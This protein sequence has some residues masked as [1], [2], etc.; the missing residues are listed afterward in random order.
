MWVTSPAILIVA[1]SCMLGMA[2]MCVFRV[3]GA[4]VCLRPRTVCSVHRPGRQQSW[5]MGV[6]GKGE[7]SPMAVL[8]GRFGVTDDMGDGT[9]R[10]SP[11]RKV[12]ARRHYEAST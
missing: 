12:V 3:M 11:L 8:A 4:V 10:V 7:D 1:S 5:C 9:G 2:W 6:A